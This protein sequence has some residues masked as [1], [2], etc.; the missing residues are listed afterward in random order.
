MTITAF[1]TEKGAYF[2]EVP[3]GIL[4][5]A[6]ID[7]ADVWKELWYLLRPMTMPGLAST[8]SAPYHSFPSTEVL[9]YPHSVPSGRFSSSTGVTK[10]FQ[11]TYFHRHV[12]NSVRLIVVPLPVAIVAVPINAPAIMVVASVPVRV[13]VIRPAADV[14]P[15]IRS[16][17]QIPTSK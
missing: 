3:K 12:A 5:A 14:D 13:A 6:R 11:S 1:K 10:P 4:E 2:C 8:G 15:D 16:R 17:L 9:G 7:G